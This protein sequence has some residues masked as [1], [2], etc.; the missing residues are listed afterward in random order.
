MYSLPQKVEK[1]SKMQRTETAITALFGSEN[2]DA[3]A[4]T[5][6]M[7][8]RMFSTLV[9]ALTHPRQTCPEIQRRVTIFEYGGNEL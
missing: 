1:F 5:R 3:L 8:R 9:L 6:H 2:L 4:N 7:S